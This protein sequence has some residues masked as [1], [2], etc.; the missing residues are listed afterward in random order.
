MHT[1]TIESDN[2]EIFN[3]IL[4]VLEHFKDEG[5]NIIKENDFKDLELIK[6]A[7]RERDTQ[8]IDTFFKSVEDAS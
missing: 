2:A 7:R 4:W 6:E 5:V 1:L 3:K 8:S